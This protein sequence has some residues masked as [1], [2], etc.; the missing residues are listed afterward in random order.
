MT[1][2]DIDRWRATVADHILK[3]KTGS[4]DSAI[5]LMSAYV[6][7]LQCGGIPIKEI[8][9]FFGAAFDEILAHEAEGQCNPARIAESLYLSRPAGRPKLS[10][11]D[12]RNRDLLFAVLVLDR[13]SAGASDLDAIDSIDREIKVL[14]IRHWAN[15]RKEGSISHARTI[16]DAWGKHRR[17]VESLSPESRDQIRSSLQSQTAPNVDWYPTPDFDEDLALLMAGKLD[18]N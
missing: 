4:R 14:P 17:D 18:A 11:R 12:L 15:R 3:A 5:W 6:R 1:E 13:V 10:E 8:V 16:A 7:A 9:V 2:P